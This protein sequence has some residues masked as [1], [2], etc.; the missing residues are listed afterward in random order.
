MADGTIVPV[1][2]DAQGRLVAQGLDGPPGPAGA[3]GA[4]G[5]T[6]PAGP[7]GPAGPGG[8]VLLTA[9]KAATST[10][11]DFVGLP[12]TLRR[13]TL[14]F[15]GLSTNGTSN[16]MF[17]LGTATSFVTANYLGGCI[18][19]TYAFGNNA[20]FLFSLNVT[21]TVIQ[22]ASCVMTSPDG[23]TWHLCGTTFRSPSGYMGPVT[24]SLTLSEPLTRIRIT[25]VL[26]TEVFDAGTV[27][28][29]G[30]A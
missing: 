5:A 29:R 4:D 28:L 11:F 9:N 6:G 17:Q 7:A 18:S 3:D 16:M 21:S 1:Q 8:G 14:L 30:E 27:H 10:A 15:S 20:G 25:T 22:Y 12:T 23:Y 19:S 13:I 24:G 2:V 26:G